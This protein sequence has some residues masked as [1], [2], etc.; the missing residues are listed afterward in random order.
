MGAEP[1]F[2]WA[3]HLAAPLLL[4]W[5]AT[6]FIKGEWKYS[7]ATMVV[8]IVVSLWMVI[9]EGEP[10]SLD[11]SYVYPAIFTLVFYPVFFG[12]VVFRFIWFMVSSVD[13]NRPGSSE[14]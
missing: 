14:S 12:V 5:L 13:T 9:S 8:T 7:V 11:W 2:E 4:I 10:M 1:F 3:P 6:F